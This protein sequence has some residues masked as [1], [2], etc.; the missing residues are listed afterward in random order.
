[1]GNQGV[2]QSQDIGQHGRPQSV[3]LTLP[4]LGVLVLERES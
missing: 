2:I 3:V 4:P 1:M